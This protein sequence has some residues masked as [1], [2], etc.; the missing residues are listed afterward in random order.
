M[1]TIA[2]K[3]L[4]HD[5]A[6]LVVT[7]VGI[8]FALVLILIQFGL[9]LG[10]LETSSNIVAQSGVDLWI[11]A[12]AIPHVNGGNALT[13][14]YRYRA[15]AVPGVE[16]VEK[17]TLFFVVWKLP[18]GAQESVQIVGF[19]LSGGMGGPWNVTQGQVA[20]LR[21]EDTVMVDE[22]YAKKLGVSKVGDSV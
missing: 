16:K 19:S 5:K 3:N 4:F 6:R 22:V 18:T 20:D 15:L 8:V 9:F 11:T 2:W 12:P 10:F 14:S 17:Y 13:E 7:L 1:L 21:G